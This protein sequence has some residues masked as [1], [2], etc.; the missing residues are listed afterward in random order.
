M[1]KSPI[2]LALALAGCQTTLDPNY[3][4]QLESYRLTL[5]SN[6]A[7]EVARANAEAARYSALAEIGHRGGPQ[8]QQLAILALALSGK[9]GGESRPSGDIV[10][11]S[12]VMAN[13]SPVAVLVSVA[14]RS[15]QGASLVR[16]RPA[17]NQTPPAMVSV[18]S[19]P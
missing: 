14:P 18:P 7:V 15:N 16:M 5:T 10:Q 13:L 12:W 17:L 6:Q 8:A 11:C 2:V 1:R 19:R 9:G 3:A 4:L